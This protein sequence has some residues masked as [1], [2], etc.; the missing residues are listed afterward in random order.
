VKLD[1]LIGGFDIFLSF[2]DNR[3]MPIHSSFSSMLNAPIYHSHK[4]QKKKSQ[5]ATEEA[6]YCYPWNY[7]VFVT[8]QMNMTKFTRLG[9]HH[10]T[11]NAILCDA[12]PTNA[13]FVGNIL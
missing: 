10:I 5:L 6:G 12:S 3:R 7:Y 2:K 1:V 13:P 9:I 11:H 8:L 4:L